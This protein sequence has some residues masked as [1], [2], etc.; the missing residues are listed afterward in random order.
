MIRALAALLAVLA[1]LLGPQ[2]LLLLAFTVTGA[3]VLVLAWSISN[4]LTE[5]GW[6]VVPRV[7]VRL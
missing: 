3:I 7:L 2:L 1:A 6:G 4:V 5:T